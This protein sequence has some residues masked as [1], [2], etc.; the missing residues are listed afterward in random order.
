MP[1]SQLTTRVIQRA[2][3]KKNIWSS[4]DA[5]EWSGIKH[6][7]L[8]RLLR[9]G[10]VPVIPVGR[11]QQQQ[12]GNGTLRR[13]ACR[14]YVIPRKAFIKWFENIGAPDPSTIGKTAA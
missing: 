3:Q 11:T 10:L 1:K 5:A 14:T 4:N 7:T 2:L 6:R 13:R 12:M 9:E 8:L